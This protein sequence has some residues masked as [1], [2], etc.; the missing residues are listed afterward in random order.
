MHLIIGEQHLP[1]AGR[2]RVV[3]ALAG[4]ERAQLVHLCAAQLEVEQLEVTRDA[5]RI[6]GL[7]QDDDPFLQLKAQDDLPGVPAVL[8]GNR[9]DDRMGQQRRIALPERAPR[10]DFYIVL[11]QDRAQ[12]LLVRDLSRVNLHRKTTSPADHSSQ[13]SLLYLKHC[14]I[15]LEF[16]D[17]TLSVF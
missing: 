10:L 2:L 8:F 9:G 5:F 4:I 6:S 17:K 11:V 16:S 12:L 14:F 13:L 3:A 1:N 7:G 15:Q